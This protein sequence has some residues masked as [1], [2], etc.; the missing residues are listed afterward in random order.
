MAKIDTGFDRLSSIIKF[1]L[2]SRSRHQVISFL[3]LHTSPFGELCG[4]STATLNSEGFVVID[5]Q[6]RYGFSDS[7]KSPPPTH[8]M[9]DHP[10]VNALRTMK[11]Q[12]IDMETI[13]SEY[14][15]IP[16]TVERKS[17]YK[18]S[19]VLPVSASR[20]YGFAFT[21]DVRSFK[22]HLS[23]FECIRSLLA[24]W[25]L[26]VEQISHGANKPNIKGHALTERQEE[27]VELIKSGR[28]NMSIAALLG[29]SESLIRQETMAIYRKLGV[30]GRKEIL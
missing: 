23:Y 28:T 9:A 14:S 10:S 16:E 21:S 8:I 15:D 29:F 7:L 26:I 17:E 20:I 5:S 1:V 11:I 30:T 22:D 19:I 12:V 25:E 18:V 6:Y 13:H 27:I 24:A 4:A 2:L 3:S